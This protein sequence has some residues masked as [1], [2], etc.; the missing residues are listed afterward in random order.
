MQFVS[1]TIGKELLTTIEKNLYKTLDK[2]TL[3]S[4]NYCFYK[5]SLCNNKNK[6]LFTPLFKNPVANCNKNAT[7]NFQ[8][9]SIIRVRN[10][11]FNN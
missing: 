5:Y 11:C 7:G 8:L 1:S 10:K 4:S 9:L 3:L 6:N 2:S